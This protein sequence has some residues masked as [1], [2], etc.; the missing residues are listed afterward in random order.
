LATIKYF[1]L[2][3]KLF[4][5][6]YYSHMFFTIKEKKM[7]NKLLKSSA[8][9]LALSSSLSN[10]S[11]AMLGVIPS[12]EELERQVHTEMTWQK[13][14]CESHLR[15]AADIALTR[16]ELRR[17]DL[18]IMCQELDERLEPKY[19]HGDEWRFTV[20]EQGR[21]VDLATRSSRSLMYAAITDAVAVPLVQLSVILETEERRLIR[22]LQEHLGPEN[23][24]AQEPELGVAQGEQGEEGAQPAGN[25]A[26]VAGHNEPG[27]NLGVDGNSATGAKVKLAAGAPTPSSVGIAEKGLH[28]DVPP[29]MYET[30]CL[31]PLFGTKIPDGGKRAA[32][33]PQNMAGRVGNTLP[34]PQSIWDTYA[35]PLLNAAPADDGNPTTHDLQTNCDT[36]HGL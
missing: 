3:D 29:T 16:G 5:A 2:L 21:A 31:N 11:E 28:S 18:C 1:F 20:N 10:Q 15:E 30:I 36:T 34:P 22:E 35:N 6:C 12:F 24:A 33:Q 4:F 23:F 7:K 19:H 27:D 32:A 25:T 13:E 8:F 14:S 9:V 26:L 17:L